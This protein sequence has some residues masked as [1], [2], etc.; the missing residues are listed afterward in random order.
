VFKKEGL[1]EGKKGSQAQK[2]KDF[3]T[4][5]GGK[6]KVTKKGERRRRHGQVLAS[7]MD[8]AGEKSNEKGTGGKKNP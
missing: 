1:T 8:S 7:K 3:L 2:K 5:I 4:T 6:G